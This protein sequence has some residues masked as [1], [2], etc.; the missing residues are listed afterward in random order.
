MWQ[1]TAYLANPFIER[2]VLYS[3]LWLEVLRIL[4]RFFANDFDKS[5]DDSFGGFYT[6]ENNY[7]LI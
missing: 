7:R 5:E 3:K 6:C 4:E 2:V 1:L